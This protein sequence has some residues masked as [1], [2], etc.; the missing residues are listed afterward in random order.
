MDG[1]RMKRDEESGNGQWVNGKRRKGGW[2]K[3]VKRM[4][5]KFIRG[6]KGHAWNSGVENERGPKGGGR[7]G[8]S[9]GG[10]FETHNQGK[11]KGRPFV[12][13]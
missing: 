9:F 10:D 6:Q 11:V 8:T 4:T 5:N 3:R 2:G 13:K 7:G 12:V 1:D